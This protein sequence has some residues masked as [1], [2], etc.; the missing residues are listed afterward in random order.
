M[1]FIILYQVGNQIF[2]HQ[3]ISHDDE[4]LESEGDCAAVP[5]KNGYSSLCIEASLFKGWNEMPRD[6]PEEM[7]SLLA[8]APKK[9]EQ[10][11]STTTS[12]PD[13][14][15]TS[16]LQGG[17]RGDE[18]R[19]VSE[20]KKPSPAVEAQPEALEGLLWDLVWKMGGGNQSHEA[21]DKHPHSHSHVA[22]ETQ[23]KKPVAFMAKKVDPKPKKRLSAKRLTE[24][25]NNLDDKLQ[26]QARR[27]DEHRAIKALSAAANSTGAESASISHMTPWAQNL[28]EEM[29][30]M[31][32]H[33]E[34]YHKERTDHAAAFAS[35]F[36]AYAASEQAAHAQ[37]PPEDSMT[38]WAHNLEDLQHDLEHRMEVRDRHHAEHEAAHKA[39]NDRIEAA[40]KVD[41]ASPFMNEINSLGR[42][43]CEDP[44]RHDSLAC[45]QFVHPDEQVAASQHTSHRDSHADSM[46]HLQLLEKHMDQLAK[47]REHDD[48]DIRKE[49]TDF[50]QELCADPARKSYPSCVHLSATTSVAPTTTG[51]G[52]RFRASVDS[53]SASANDHQHKAVQHVVELQWTPLTESEVASRPHNVDA[54]PFVMGRREL[55]GHHWEGRIPKVAC[56]TVLPHGKV[57][58]VLMQY[59]MDNYNLQ[60]YEGQREL[61]IV[62]HSSD[63]EAARIAHLYADGTSVKAAGAHSGDTHTISY[64]LPLWRLGGER[65]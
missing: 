38:P 20:E 34:H 15:G 35:A 4:A 6:S 61:V 31:Q 33:M 37:Q 43:L 64:S 9:T 11:A 1:G 24:L 5:G 23:H 51:K 55:R 58:E 17:L 60:S 21:P 3:A 19:L 36:S 52:S 53:S 50:L 41:T 59:F 44:Q 22:P 12:L 14:P 62:Y 2:L 48:E 29:H 56:V 49:S 46:M 26:A 13:T 16:G 7:A 42:E 65:C 40:A 10:A 47:D 8:I 32:E 27:R 39:M 18:K 45:A 25:Q 57:T 28:M 30:Q 63:A 54:L